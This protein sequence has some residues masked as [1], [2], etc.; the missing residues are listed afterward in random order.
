VSSR[1]ALR[2]QRH[3]HSSRH[4]GKAYCLRFFSALASFFS[5]AVF[6]AGFLVSFLESLDFMRIFASNKL[7]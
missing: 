7:K 4:D 2:A 6:V 5:L 1:S 3:L